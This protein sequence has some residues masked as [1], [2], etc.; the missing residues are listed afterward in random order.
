MGVVLFLL[1]MFALALLIYRVKTKA[2][3]ANQHLLVCPHCQTKGRINR[4]LD[5]AKG[6]ISGGKATGA[7][8][9][10]GLSLLVTG[11]SRKTR[12]TRNHCGA[13]NTTW[14]S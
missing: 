3:R 9:T 1:A 5:T 2:L 12:V 8:L 6:P 11:L 7:I 4:S 14:Y 13:C 10:G